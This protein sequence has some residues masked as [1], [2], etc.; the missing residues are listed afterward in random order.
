[1][2]KERMKEIKIIFFLM[3][4][5]KKINMGGLFSS[6]P[7]L[8]VKEDLKPCPNKT[9]TVVV[10]E[11]TSNRDQNGLSISKFKKFVTLCVPIDKNISDI[12]AFLKTT[13]RTSFLA[14]SKFW[15]AP[16][17]IN[18]LTVSFASPSLFDTEVTNDTKLS[19]FSSIYVMY[20]DKKPI[21]TPVYNIQTGNKKQQSSS[22]S[23][24]SSS[25]SPS[26]YSSSSSSSSTKKPKPTGTCTKQMKQAV[27]RRS[28]FHGQCI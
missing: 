17:L 24:S 27:Q 13:F 10:L 8:M 11:Y 25:S 7:K 22:P 14:D 16:T 9:C 23:P 1:M 3:S 4:K 18:D 26:S 5:D 21:V 15:Y 20:N 19:N 28:A 6:P 12:S 2:K